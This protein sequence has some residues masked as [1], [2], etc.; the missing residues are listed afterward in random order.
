M[1]E[2][3]QFIVRSL[4]SGTF[5]EDDHAESLLQEFNSLVYGLK[6]F[7]GVSSVDIDSAHPVYPSSEVRHLLYFRFGYIAAL[8]GNAAHERKHVSKALMVRYEYHGAVLGK[9]LLPLDVDGPVPLLKDPSGPAVGH[10]FYQFLF[11]F[12]VVMSSEIVYS[13]GIGVRPKNVLC[14]EQNIR[15]VR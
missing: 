4:G 11:T 3:S 10:L 6:G 12:R 2:F 9:V 15:N 7:S 8:E 13:L 5:R 1:V 14:Q